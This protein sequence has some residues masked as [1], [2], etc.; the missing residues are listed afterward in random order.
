MEYLVDGKKFSLSYS[1]LEEHVNCSE[2][3]DEFVKKSKLNVETANELQ[4]AKYK[5]FISTIK[6]SQ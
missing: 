2:T 5:R 4:L 1:E 3:L 6:K